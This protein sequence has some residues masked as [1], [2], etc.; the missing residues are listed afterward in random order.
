METKPRVSSYQPFSQILN[1]VMML[2]IRLF[3]SLTLFKFYFVGRIISHPGTY[4]RGLILFI[5]FCN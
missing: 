4:H 5:N 1:F 3:D 2:Q